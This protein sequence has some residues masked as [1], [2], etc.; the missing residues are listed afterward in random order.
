MRPGKPLWNR[1]HPGQRFCALTTDVDPATT[2]RCIVDDPTPG[3]ENRSY[4]LIAICKV[5]V[6]RIHISDVKWKVVADGRR[7]RMGGV[8]FGDQSEG[9][10]KEMPYP[11]IVKTLFSPKV[12]PMTPSSQP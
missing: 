8:A 1:T 11:D 2:P 12:M 6:G 3:D 10:P 9:S 4:L 7:E 5:T